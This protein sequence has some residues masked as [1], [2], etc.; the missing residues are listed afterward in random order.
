MNCT[1]RVHIVS[2]SVL[3]G[4]YFY[5]VFIVSVFVLDHIVFNLDRACIIYVPYLHV[6]GSYLDGICLQSIGTILS[7]M[8]PICMDQICIA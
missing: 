6:T 4:I 1:Y 7:G 5:G 8:D 2:V 3:F